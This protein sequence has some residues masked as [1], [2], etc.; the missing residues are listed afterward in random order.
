[1]NSHQNKVAV[2]DLAIGLIYALLFLVLR[3][4]I[5]NT[6]DQGE[7]LPLVYKALQPSL[8]TNDFYVSQAWNVF[9]IRFYYVQLLAFFGQWFSVEQLSWYF[10]VLCLTSSAVAWIRIARH[11]SADKVS[12]YLAPFFILFLFYGWTVGGNAVQYNLLICST[13]AKAIAPWALYLALKDRWSWAAILLGISGLFQILVSLQLALVLGAYLLF[14][15]RWKKSIS[16][17]VLW[18]LFAAPMLLPVAF[19]QLAAGTGGNDALF[20]KV[21][22]EVRNPHHYLPSLF[23]WTSYAKAVFLWII[24]WIAF[25]WVA[26]KAIFR[27]V[28]LWMMWILAGLLM[29]TFLLEALD[30][31][32]IGKLQFFK[33]TIW[34]SAFSSAF[35]AVTLEVWLLRYTE[36]RWIPAVAVFLCLFWIA[37]SHVRFDTPISFNHRS[38]QQKELSGVHQWIREHTPEDALFATFATNESFICEARRS[39]FVAWNPIIHEPAFMDEWFRRFG[40][41]YHAPFQSEDYLGTLDRSDTYFNDQF[42]LQPPFSHAL[43]EKTRGRK[44]FGQI[45]LE[46][47]H[48]IVVSR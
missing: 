46:T 28:S 30:W 27:K 36:K 31:K 48:F 15:G 20:Y 25:R 23:A 11:L 13:F 29:Y 19:R 33:T 47:E 34:L 8:Y 12:G 44:Y 43:F 18:F 42:Q 5:F 14:S 7:H 32:S 10:N 39:Q 2:T 22:Y 3:G 26:D 35:I 37:Q 40:L 4:Y 45:L 38:E 41:L 24:G 16:F 21:L 6:A 9:T 17:G 1:M